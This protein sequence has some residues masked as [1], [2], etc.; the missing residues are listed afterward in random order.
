MRVLMFG[1][2]FPPHLS[3]GLGT[4]CYGLTRALAGRGTEIRFVLPRLSQDSVPLPRRLRLCSASGVTLRYSSGDYARIVQRLDEA[5]QGRLV[6][7]SWRAYSN[8]VMKRFWEKHLHVVP[9]DSS[10][11]PYATEES[12]QE[13]IESKESASVFQEGGRSWLQEMQGNDTRQDWN[14]QKHEETIELHGGYGKDLMS[15][16]F[17]YSQ[18]ALSVAGND[19][20]VI[21]AHDWMTYPAGMAVKQATGKPLVVHIHALECDRSGVNMN[22]EVSAIEKAGMEAADVVVAVSH[23][24]KSRVARLYGIPRSKIEV[25]HN[26]FTRS[27]AQSTLKVSPPAGERRVLFMGRITYQ[28]GPEYFVEAARMVLNRL[29]NVRFIMAGSGDMLSRMVRRVAKLRLGSRFHFTGFLRGEDVDRMYAMSAVFVMPGVSEPFGIAPLEAMAY[30][31]PVIISRQSGVSEVVKH[32]LKVNFWDVRDMADKICA[33]LTYRCLSE[34]MIR[35]CR[36]ELK[37]IRWENAADS[38]NAIY[39]RCIR[40]HAKGGC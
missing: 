38:L 13:S 37:T 8:N 10:L 31:V 6:P 3:G 21:H 34:E 5:G 18:A 32:A 11:F 9:V 12:Y 22:T 4:A 24:T 30:D 29:P 1:W 26:A 20:D 19:F 15:E 14:E 7:E 2:E 17:R 16:V 27:E 25:V 36:K 33:A 40:E 35:N 28:K 39:A 23:Y